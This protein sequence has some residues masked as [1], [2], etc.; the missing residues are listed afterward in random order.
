MRPGTLPGEEGH[1]T[2]HDSGPDPSGVAPRPGDPT[3]SNGVPGATRGTLV[4]QA[5]GGAITVGRRAGRTILVGRQAGEVHVC[6]GADD[7]GVSRQHGLLTCDG[8]R[9]WVRN[10]GRNPIR[11]PMTELFA[12]GEAAPLAPGYTALFVVGSGGRVHQVE[13]YVVGDDGTRPTP[14]HDH[15]TRQPRAWTL[16]DV[17]RLALLVL[18][19]RYL[20]REP[21]PQPLSWRDAAA[22]LADLD[23]DGGWTQ[24]SVERR[25]ARLR[26]R[27]SGAG[28]SRVLGHEV[29]PPLGNQL[30][31]N[32]LTELIRSATLTH[33]DLARLDA[34]TDD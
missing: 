28:M 2:V 18:G 9:W 11:M 15:E 13:V 4:V 17:E 25:V 29:T 3:L 19:R 8:D 26:E 23:P 30:N 22:E 33:V 20:R 5:I 10:V 21:D 32:L 6:V 14:R 12:N 27:L 24:K 16:S 31:H 1:M 7:L 34:W